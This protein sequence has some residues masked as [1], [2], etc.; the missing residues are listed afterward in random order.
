MRCGRSLTPGRQAR[1]WRP[2]WKGVGCN[3]R[4]YRRSK[5]SGLPPS[6]SK[7]LG[8]PEA[9]DSWIPQGSCARYHWSRSRCNPPGLGKLPS[10]QSRTNPIH[11]RAKGRSP[12]G[13]DS[14]L[15]ILSSWVKLDAERSLNLHEKQLS[16]TSPS[17]YFHEEAFARDFRV[18]RDFCCP[19]LH[20]LQIRRFLFA[21]SGP[22]SR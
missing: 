8:D 5:A 20:K 7:G 16:T 9:K 14:I 3:P 12:L 1:G 19:R 11:S 4:S 15:A 10:Q 13:V 6:S 22:G 2:A 17:V 18:N 21:V